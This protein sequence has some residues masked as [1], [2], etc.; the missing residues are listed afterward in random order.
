MKTLKKYVA[1]LA[2]AS[3]VLGPASALAD[4]VTSFTASSGAAQPT[5]R[6][7]AKWETTGTTLADYWI[8]DDLNTTGIQVNPPLVKA[9]TKAVTYC[10]VVQFPGKMTQVSKV[11]MDLKYAGTANQGTQY[12]QC[13][14]TVGD[15]LELTKVTAPT[16]ELPYNVF[17]KSLNPNAGAG[18]YKGNDIVTFLDPTT[19]HDWAT[20]CTDGVEGSLPK[21]D[22]ALYCGT[23]NL[24]YEAAAGTYEV[25]VH[26]VANGLNSNFLLNNYLY[27]PQAGFQIDFN[28]INYGT[29]T[30]TD[31]T[32]IGI[33]G[34]HYNWASS[35]VKWNSISGDTNFTSSVGTNNATVRN[36]GNVELDMQVAQ[37]YMNTELTGGMDNIRYMGRVGSLDGYWQQYGPN[38]NMTNPNWTKLTRYI[39]L[40]NKDEMDFGVAIT[41]FDQGVTYSGTMKLMGTQHDFAKCPTRISLPGEADPAQQTSI[42]L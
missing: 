4:V 39:E 22:A 17:C 21:G 18:I 26:G 27:V 31:P 20:L 35:F 19:G 7:V 32:V 16:G 14:V 29:A 23:R 11:Y 36:I 24:S 33:T 9:G 40:S 41:K 2:L 10:A 13:G 34:G 15:E 12:N 38:A 42:P 28:K 1:M 37:D 8:D 30:W 6:V 5:F 3:L 25:Q